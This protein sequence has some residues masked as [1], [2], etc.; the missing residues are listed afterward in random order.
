[1]T[2]TDAASGASEDWAFGTL[3]AK[4]T[5]VVELRDEG[6]YGFLLPE[7]QIEATALETFEALKEV[8]KSLVA[9]Y[10]A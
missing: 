4:Y 10:G 2:S 8:G 1:M 6:R 5:Y 9:E 7:S 3:G